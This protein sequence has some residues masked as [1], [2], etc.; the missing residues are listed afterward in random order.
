MY[1][2]LFD[3]PK[4]FLVGHLAT[5]DRCIRKQLGNFVWSD[6]VVE[7]FALANKI[8]PTLRRNFREPRGSILP[9][10]TW[11][12]AGHLLNLDIVNACKTIP[13]LH[14]FVLSTSF[15]YQETKEIDNLYLDFL[16]DQGRAGKYHINPEVYARIAL[17]CIAYICEEPHE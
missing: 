13:S 2:G 5:L 17:R 1:G 3:V 12:H 11:K 6:Q 7:L 10:Y 9:P 14:R 8:Q 15:T 16:H 4:E